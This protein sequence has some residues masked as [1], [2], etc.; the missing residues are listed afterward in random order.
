MLWGSEN[1]IVHICTHV[2]GSKN[3]TY[4]CLP[5][6]TAAKNYDKFSVL[7]PQRRGG[8]P[9]MPSYA[10]T[11]SK[12]PTPRPQTHSNGNRQS[13]AMATNI[14]QLSGHW[15]ST[16][17]LAGSTWHAE[18]LKTKELWVLHL[19]YGLWSIFSSNLKQQ[20]KNKKKKCTTLF[21]LVKII[22]LR[23]SI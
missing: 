23:K 20:T 13:N 14:T 15:G 19:V 5:S 17:T 4:D 6:W 18:R 22:D 16:K 10:R 7:A 11:D 2:L 21:L 3:I 1:Y 8:S 9:I 12:V